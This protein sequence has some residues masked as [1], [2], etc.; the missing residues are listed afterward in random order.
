MVDRTNSGKQYALGSCFPGVHFNKR[1]VS[2]ILALHSGETLSSIAESN[3]C[4]VRTICFYI[5]SM[6]KK[7]SCKTISELIKCIRKSDLL[8]RFKFK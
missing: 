6:K 3:N 8:D 4:T 5:E 2:I 1:E 7:L